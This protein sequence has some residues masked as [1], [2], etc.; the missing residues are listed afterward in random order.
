MELYCGMDLHS[1]NTVIGI[2]DEKRKHLIDQKLPNDPELIRSFLKPFKSDLK[3]IVVESTYNWYWLADILQ[4]DGYRVHL[5]HPVANEHYNGLKHSNDKHSLL[6]GGVAELGDPEGGL[7]LSE[8]GPF[9][10]GCSEEAGTSGPGSNRP[11][12]ESSAHDFSQLRREGQDRRYQEIDGG[13]HFSVFGE[14][15]SLVA[16]GQDQQRRDRLSDTANR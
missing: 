5:S 2:I 10:A 6:V 4:E 7:Y 14:R 8:T 16:G 15:G 9:C 13:C 3:G 12:R 11:D 1:S